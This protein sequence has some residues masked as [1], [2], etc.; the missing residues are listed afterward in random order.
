MAGP[1]I[2]TGNPTYINA[3]NTVVRSG[4]LQFLGLFC[5]YAASTP[6]IE[7]YN[8]VTSGTATIVPQF[9][10]AAGTWYPLPISLATGLTIVVGGTV[11]AVISWNPQPTTSGT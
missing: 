2:E 8:A 3:A 9:T 10:P 7:L 6:T 4:A 1:V 11:R 5:A